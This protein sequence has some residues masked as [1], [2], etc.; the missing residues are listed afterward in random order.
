VAVIGAGIAGASIAAVL[1]ASAK[2]LLIEAE[3]HPGYHSTGRSAALFTEHYGNWAVRALTRA[4]RPFFEDPPGAFARA[5]LLRPRPAL[6]IA[7]MDQLA[8]LRA[9]AELEGPRTVPISPEAA[10]LL[11]PALQ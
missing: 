4:A 2:V 9:L 11:C 8:S 5:A 3:T 7:R 6:W 1:S 10:A